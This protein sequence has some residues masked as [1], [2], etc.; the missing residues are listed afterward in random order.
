MFAKRNRHSRLITTSHVALLATA[1]AILSNYAFVSIGREIL[2]IWVNI[3]LPGIFFGAVLWW[4]FFRRVG[5]KPVKGVVIV[6]LTA[7]A[8]FCAWLSANWL[9]KFLGSSGAIG[10]GA[11]CGMLGGLVGTVILSVGP[12][13]LSSGTSQNTHCHSHDSDWCDRRST[14]RV[15]EFI[16]KG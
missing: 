13:N 12:Q 2:N 11:E 16:S 15:R 7:V 4:A 6:F 5:I 9:F 1:S 8:W 10:V 3:L 14:S